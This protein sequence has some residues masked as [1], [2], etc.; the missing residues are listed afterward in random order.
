MEEPDLLFSPAMSR[1][2]SPRPAE[3]PQN[4]SFVVELPDSATRCEEAL[5]AGS[6]E[7]EEEVEEEEPGGSRSPASQQSL[8]WEP[9]P[10]AVAAQPPSL[11]QEL[12][13]ADTRPDS[14][15]K[16]SDDSKGKKL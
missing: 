2:P 12:L 11:Q 10:G 9:E 13:S 1:T 4:P 7:E 15:P 14:S 5:P 3:A 6:L 8:E 16:S